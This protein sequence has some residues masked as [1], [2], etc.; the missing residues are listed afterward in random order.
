MRSACVGDG[1]CD[2]KTLTG[3]ELDRPT[4][5]MDFADATGSQG[6]TARRVRETVIVNREP[7]FFKPDV[8]HDEVTNVC[9]LDSPNLVDR[10]DY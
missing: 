7:G 5:V 8:L 1:G 2:Y 4:D 3:L 9:L 6:E 10:T